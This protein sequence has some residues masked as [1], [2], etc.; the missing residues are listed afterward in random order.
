MRFAPTILFVFLITNA[1][2]GEPYEPTRVESPPILDGIL[3][4]PEWNQ[5]LLL[6]DFFQRYPREGATPSERTEVRLLYTTQSLYVGF[7]AFDRSPQSIAATVM[8][9][10]D[11]DVVNND[12]FAMAV[13]SYNDERNGYWFSTNPLGARVD[14]QFF[15]EGNNW[16]SNWNGI[17]SCQTRI[18][19]YGWTAEI[20]IPFSTLRFKPGEN[21]VMG[22]NFFRRIIRSNEQLF[23]PLIPLKYSNGT[24]NV[25]V[26]RKYVFQNIAGGHELLLKPHVVSGLKRTDLFTSTD[27]DAGIDV[28]YALTDSLRSN[29]SI[30]TDFAEA[31]VD[32][33]QI[34][35]SRFRLFFPEKRDFFLENAGSFQFGLPSETEVFFSRRIGLTD[36]GETVP[37][38]FGA[39][40][41]GKI[42]GL[43]L[44]L[45]NA[46]T[47]EKDHIADENFTVVRAKA[48]VGTRSYVGGIF[49]NRWAN[50]SAAKNSFGFDLNLYLKE[51][52]ALSAF[53]A[54]ISDP[55]SPVSWND[56]SAVSV[57]L[58][59]SGE[60]TS[61]RTSFTEIGRSFNPAIG[62][63]ERTGIRRFDGFLFQPFYL[64]SKQLRT[65]TPGIEINSTEDLSGNF[66]D[67]IHRASLR[68][69]FPSEDEINLFAQHSRET[70][71]EPFPIFRDVFVQKGQY[72]NRQ[73]GISF[74]TKPGRKVSASMIVSSGTLYAGTR[75]GAEPSLQWKLNRHFTF[76]QFLSMNR[77]QM[78]DE[79]FTLSLA[80]SRISY[81]LNT[82]LSLAS[83]LQY[84]NSSQELGVNVRF[85]Y[86][87]HEGTE[88]FVVYDEINDD[89][90]VPVSQ[91]HNN[92]RFLM[93]FTYLFDL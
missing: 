23:A 29:F 68:F 77:I 7:R 35:L 89:R 17:W 66:T 55:A 42:S 58:G 33:R 31:E 25:S 50:G 91:K 83:L 19:A 59:R 3:D 39:K 82:H 54:T 80:R 73:S 84:D 86:L 90:L 28:R 71:P 11:F 52:I 43:E 16:E 88:L 41:T 12:Q 64:N 1:Y 85:S 5:A 53:A 51:E 87:F 60:R 78:P 72:D 13:D 36:H 15:E 75:V 21:N 30:N 34:N 46:Q 61:F 56:R 10:D 38:L 26:A 76:T 65:V 4:E 92:K 32:E 47:N 49:T 67:Q 45:L 93:K 20:E 63:V 48:G 81:S 27:H 24:P 69:V 2:A 22:I 62:F 9:R 18:D 14:A 57:A 74:T 6:S 37:I 79:S 44:G 8:Q 40:L 70:I